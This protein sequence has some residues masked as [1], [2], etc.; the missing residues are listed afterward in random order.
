MGTGIP[1]CVLAGGH[2]ILKAPN[3]VAGC[4]LRPYSTKPGVLANEVARYSAKRVFN[5]YFPSRSASIFV[6]T[7]LSVY[8]WEKGASVAIAR[9]A[10]PG[11]PGF[12]SARRDSAILTVFLP[13]QR[14]SREA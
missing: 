4:M 11:H 8:F 9:A 14:P 10:N 7:R 5:M 12:V 2:R 3:V 1:W 13:V 6:R